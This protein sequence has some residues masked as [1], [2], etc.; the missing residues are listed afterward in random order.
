[1][2]KRLLALCTIL[3]LL[4]TLLVASPAMI[5]PMAPE[6]KS[7][8][9]LTMFQA[10]KFNAH[11]RVPRD[12]DIE[13]ILREE[14]VLLSGADAAMVQAAV[15]E[16]R[17]E[18]AKRNP[19]TPSPHKLQALLRK[20]RGVA[21]AA[22]AT[23]GPEPSETGIKSLVVP[24]EFPGEDTFDWCG[25]EVTTTG[26]LH[27]EI[28]PPGP[29]DNNTVWYE[30]TSPELYDELYYGVGPDAG[31]VVH[32][33]NLG[34][35]DLRGSTMANY[36]L[37]Q[38][39]GAFVPTGLIY[40][41]WLQAAHSEGWY[42]QDSC[43]GG[44]SN[45]YAHILVAEAVDQ[46]N[47]DDPDFAWQDFD[48]DGDG[49]VDNFTVI[50][51]GI[52]QEGGGGAQGDFAIWSH[53]SVIE[54][55]TG[56]L[57]CTAGST[58][59]P[60]RDIYVLEYSMDPENIDVG[61]IAEEFGHAAFGLPDIYTTDYQLSVA[62]W[63][64][65]EAGSWNGPLGGMQPAPFPLWFRYIIGWSEPVE[66]DY[67]TGPTMV[68]VGQHSLRPKGTEQGIK[69]NLPDQD[70]T[71]PNPLDTGDAWW[72]DLGDL[73]LNTLTHEF[74]LTGTT[75]PVFSFASYWSIEEDW[76]GG[77]VE[78]ST[79]GGATWTAL[80]DMDGYFTQNPLSGNNPDLNWVLTGED[81]GTLRFDLS[82][83]A[84]QSV[85][86]R[87]LYATDMA[88]QWDGWWGD[89]FSLDDG[90]TNLFSDDVEGGADGWI[91]DGWGI[92]PVTNIYPRYYLVEWRNLSGFDRGLQYPYQTVYSDDDEWEVDRAPY[93]V[94]GMLVWYRDAAYGFDYTL[95]DSW[96]DPP[97]WGPKHALIMVDSHPY[98]YGWDDYTYD[99]GA[100]VR[101][102]GR[103]QAA[104]AAFTL[105][106][107]S[108]FTIRLG[109]D[110]DTGEYVE[111]PLETKTFGPRPGVSQFHDSVGYYPGF[112]F[113]GDGYLYWWDID[114][115]AVV[116]A[117]GD[118][119]TKI[120]DL[121][122]NPLYDLYGIDVGGTVLGSGNPGDDG[123]Q[124][125]LHLAVASQASNGKW[126]LIKVWNSP[127]VLELEKTVSSAQARPGQRIKYT[128]K[129]R[130]TNP[131]GQAFVV[132]DP[133]P[134]NTTFVWGRHFDPATNSIHWQH[135]VPAG[136][137][138]YISFVVRVNP[139]T[140]VG[141]I[142]TNEAYLS[143]SALGDS[144]SV[145]TEVVR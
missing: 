33:P 90:A 75:A 138:R 120:T 117:Q 13:R 16:F 54:W 5:R 64:I 55:P 51:A 125:G 111:T 23:G 132:D 71:I 86:V 48:S 10:A 26:P 40:P 104:D 79:D 41:N 6:A 115:S 129:V 101:L 118:Y 17:Q 44:N 77:Y 94:P 52:G 95:S 139:D 76:D 25:T 70:I 140:P 110:P 137:A 60:D 30:D 126:G 20:E 2:S 114:A 38:S 35:V 36:Y 103:V 100:S 24:V 83:Y 39:E 15:R 135:G 28:A 93:T 31:V 19:T 27:N 56:H 123:V 53:A 127:G 45:V 4:T 3:T 108:P 62:N 42:G 144:A 85:L 128:L 133:I 130:N 99:T 98:P 116:P 84:G 112:Y 22:M 68:K 74:D 67:T 59:C 143:D 109:Y 73:V 89:D 8:Q 82:T 66:L 81:T 11:Y 134:E 61:V 43:D 78:V 80:P 34:D 58:G 29:R 47:F 87:L 142:I 18:W 1:M 37:E 107:T 102:S 69:I 91:S 141:T 106:D 46:V 131:V 50:H 124:F 12:E 119:T 7:V 9:S 145:T 122:Y 97:S 92:V 96:Y 72:S 63:A 21:K 113:T 49:H 88:V 57:A 136:R 105:Q 121:D 32:H 65:M 14:G